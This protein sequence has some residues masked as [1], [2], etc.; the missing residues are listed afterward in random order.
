[1]AHRYTFQEI[2]ALQ[3]LKKT[4]CKHTPH[5]LDIDGAFVDASIDEVAMVGGYSMFILMTKLPGERIEYD[6][7]WSK[8][9][10]E[11]EKTRAAFKTAMMLA[12]SNCAVLCEIR[13]D[14]QRSLEVQSRSAGLQYAQPY[15]G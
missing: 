1:M 9:L 7:F 12:K 6:M 3:H 11:R 14:Q 2:R 13:T 15:V 5:L 4:N 8:A 10:E